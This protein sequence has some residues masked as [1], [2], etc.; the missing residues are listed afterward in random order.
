MLKARVIYTEQEDAYDIEINTGDGWGLCT[1]YPCHTSTKNPMG[2]AD[3]ISFRILKEIVH[4]Q[5]I[6]YTISF[7]V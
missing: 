5:N 6:G 4:L 7:K 2:N 1:R 3:Y